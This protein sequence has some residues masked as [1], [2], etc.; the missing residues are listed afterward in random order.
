MSS[1]RKPGMNTDDFA[2]AVIGGL[3]MIAFVLIMIALLG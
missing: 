1:H 2:L 3:A